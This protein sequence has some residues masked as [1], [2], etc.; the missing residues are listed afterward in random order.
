MDGINVTSLEEELMSMKGNK[1]I[2]G[3]KVFTSG[4]RFKGNWT[5]GG[6]IDGVNIT[7]LSRSAMLLDGDQTVTGHKVRTTTFGVHL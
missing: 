5:I 2:K 6:L 1:V 4:V 3:T 7:E